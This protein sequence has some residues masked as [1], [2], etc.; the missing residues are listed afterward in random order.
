MGTEH[1]VVDAAQGA[2]RDNLTDVETRRCGISDTASLVCRACGE[3]FPY[4]L[5]SCDRCDRCDWSVAVSRAFIAAHAGC[6]PKGTA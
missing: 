6:K 4:P 3:R 1:V 2:M 5:G